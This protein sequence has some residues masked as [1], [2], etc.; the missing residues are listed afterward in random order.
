MS[1]EIKMS[2]LFTAT[3]WGICIIAFG[4]T[5]IIERIFNVKI[6]FAKILIGVIFILIGFQL[7]VGRDNINFKKISKFKNDQNGNISAVFANEEINLG[8]YHFNQNDELMI[9]SVF[10]NLTIRVPDSLSYQF[11]VKNLLSETSLPY[12]TSAPI[13]E[14]IHL[15][16]G[17]NTNQKILII[18]LRNVMSF[19]EVIKDSIEIENVDGF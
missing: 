9:K 4:V 12:I 8:D 2:F 17:K 3:F 5:L 14:S 16:N 11:E 6:S 1:K 10:S 19:V 18:K 15:I 7:L 13:S